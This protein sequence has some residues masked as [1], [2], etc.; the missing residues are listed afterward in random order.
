MKKV[1][2][3]ILFSWVML[4]PTEGFSEATQR[5]LQFQLTDDQFIHSAPLPIRFKVKQHDQIEWQITSNKP[6]ELHMH[7]YGI[8]VRVPKNQLVVYKF[9][10]KATGKFQIEWH[11][12]INPVNT[13]PKSTHSPSV[14]LEVYPQ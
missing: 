5:V 4:H 9:Q 8:E 12:Q 6:G 10:A 14:Y 1:F 3:L 13:N 2:C 11:P 7:A